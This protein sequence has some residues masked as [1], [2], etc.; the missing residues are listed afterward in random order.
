MKRNF[1]Q[2]TRSQMKCTIVK[3]E[4]YQLIYKI[5]TSVRSATHEKYGTCRQ[6]NIQIDKAEIRKE[7]K[8]YRIDTPHPN[9]RNLPARL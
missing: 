4:K 7:W 8:F 3:Y 2:N 6:L 9:S 1:K 5:S